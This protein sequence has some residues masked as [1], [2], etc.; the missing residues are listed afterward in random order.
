MSNMPSIPAIDDIRGAAQRIVGHAHRTPVLT[1]TSLDVRTGAKLF[2]KCENLQKAGAFK[3]RGALNAVMSLPDAQAA[4]GVV[5]HS[6]GN[7]A[8]ALALAAQIRGIPAYVVM[9]SDAP[10]VKKAAVMAYGGRITLCEPTLSARQATADRLLQEAGAVLVHPYDDPAVIA[11]QGTAALELHEQVTN[12]DTVVVPIS[13]GGLI[14]G[15]A[16]VTAAV[17]PRCAVIGAEPELADDAY[18]SLRSGRLEPAGRGIT[19]ADGLRATLSERTFGVISR[20][21]REIITVSDEEIGRAMRLLWERLKIVVE[22]SGSVPFAAVLKTA[23]NLRGR[24]VGVVL[25]GGNLDLDHV[26]WQ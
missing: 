6:S 4:R 10:A 13:G 9:P 12:L 1:S 19:I 25:S 2:F 17:A 7:H 5:T 15:I 8:A 16:L 22:P 11:G 14:S 21:V 24:R 26:P 23:E 20:F 18:R 3:F